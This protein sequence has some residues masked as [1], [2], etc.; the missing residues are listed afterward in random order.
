MGVYDLIHKSW[1][2]LRTAIKALLDLNRTFE[3][4]V[5]RIN[6]GPSL[7][8][9]NPTK[10]Y[11]LENPPFPEL[12][13]TRSNEL[14][15]ETDVIIIGS[16][17]T[18]AAVAR[19]LLQEGKR[20][21]RD[22]NITILE[23]RDICSG[24]TGRNG[25]HIK[26]SPHE[27]FEA[28]EKK[29]GTE[30]AVALT[31]FQLRHLECLTELCRVESFVEAECRVVET[32]DLF[33]D[34]KAFDKACH[35]LG[36]MKTLLPEFDM[37]SYQR[38]DAREKFAVSDHVVGALSYRAGAIWP[39]RFVTAVWNK[40]L[41]E[42]AGQITIETNT[43]VL[44]VEREQSAGRS[45]KVCTDRGVIVC[46]HIVHATNAWMGHLLPS[47]KSKSTGTRAHM[48]AQNPGYHGYQGFHG[49]RSW[50]IVYGDNDYDYMTQRPSPDGM[51][52]IMLGG[53]TFRSKDN[54]LDQIGVWD[55]SQI[56][57]FTSAHLAGILPIIF[58]SKTQ[59]PN[60]QKS[61]RSLQQHWSGIIAL[62]A[63]SLPFVGELDA[64]LSGRGFV[65]EDASEWIS[66]G[67]NGQGMVYAW[68]CGTALGIIITGSEL[69]DIPASP[70][71]P[72]GVLSEWFPKE[73]LLD[74]K[75]YDK[76][77]ILDLADEL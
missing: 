17:I 19:S 62:T 48:S 30:R 55:D 45:Y 7:P 58:S 61:A 8:N 16:G 6:H 51:S 34:Q 39:Y 27:S 52:D 35:T 53:G 14:P 11:W 47:L 24:A 13:N 32:V 63:D 28:F 43:Q 50:S 70:G 25:G 44:S 68:L 4:L 41:Q 49:D 29:F 59:Q 67:Y 72:G 74:R 69:E 60:T 57:A 31:K 12:V 33:L 64:G 15:T 3:A 66:A 71:F 23:A 37:H 26:V 38:K 9:R 42:Y 40:L 76:I 65:T 1:K 54:G 36:R 10:S 73:M 56:D 18:G 22:I 46:N 75:R 21:G 2:T 5:A 20:N 77:D